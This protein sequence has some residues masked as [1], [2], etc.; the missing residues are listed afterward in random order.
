MFKLSIRQILRLRSAHNC[1]KY[2]QYACQHQFAV[3]RQFHTTKFLTEK[4]EVIAPTLS[5]QINKHDV[6]SENEFLVHMKNDP[7]TFG[8]QIVDE[9]IDED[10]AK[11]EKYLQEVGDRSKQL[12]TKQYADM[13]KSFIRKRKIKEAIDVV[14]VKM[15]K[16]DR[17]KPENYLY[18]LL[19][20]ACGRV[21][22][23]KK[24]FS[25][26]NNMKKRG[27]V[28]TDGTYTALFNACANSPWPTTDGL[29]RA[30]H[31]HN[32]MIEKRHEPNDS[33]YN[34]MIKAY[35]RGGDLISAFAVVDEMISKKMPIKDDTLNFLLQACISDKE[36]GFRH[37]LLVWRKF[38]DKGITPSIFTYNL[39]LRSIR[40]C[41]L[42]DLEVTKDVLTKILP[43]GDKFLQLPEVHENP[44]EDK[45]GELESFG[46]LTTSDF[47]KNYENV[48]NIQSSRPNLM[49]KVPHLGNI[50]SL[51]E[52]KK[53]S[54]RLLLLGG[55]SAYIENM[56][57]NN[58]KPDIKT[59]T[60]MLN[61]IP[62]TNVAEN[63]VL[64]TMK[65][66]G[67]KPDLDFYN[68][69]IK[70]RS[71]R[72]DYESAKE[73]LGLIKTARFEPD[74]ITYGVL[75][76]GC[77]NKEEATEFLAYFNQAGLR[78]NTEILGAMLKQACFHFNFSYII[79]I[80]AICTKENIKPNKIFMQHLEDFKKKC[81]YGKDG[82]ER[83]KT[84]DKNYQVF[85]MKYNKFKDE[86]ELEE[87]EHPWTQYRQK[88]D[89]DVKFYNDK[90]ARF[91]ARHTSLY[92]QKKTPVDV[93]HKNNR[94]RF[95]KFKPKQIAE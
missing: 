38:V 36:A 48:G 91:K 69:L 59:Y 10:D 9:I 86:V 47:N 21:G 53:P 92:R 58:C 25:L 80:L 22:Y 57:E 20:G 74:I 81:K 37:A 5:K 66:L 93:V 61:C 29:T 63:N 88:T 31:L 84:F 14:E 32:I 45:F 11:E 7:D 62:G 51:S 70:K 12:S 23:T 67:T 3:S 17:V 78:L 15:L 19:L 43:Q 56:L 77:K 68:M 76:L 85:K 39:L 16:E 49:A 26:Y 42:G 90:T 73:V 72:A 1:L 94:P 95:N 13:I 27:L 83:S 33:N 24:A 28:V 87:E 8:Q 52:V 89:T 60:Q 18:N 46:K 82:K 65:K 79:E 30:K 75:A 44:I 40:D 35:G 2:S 41:G 54:D 55:A 4:S 34:A 50:I 71:M 64:L 6:L